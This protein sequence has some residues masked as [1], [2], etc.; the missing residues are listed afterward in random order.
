MALWTNQESDVI[1]SRISWNVNLLFYFG[2]ILKSIQNSRIEILHQ[3]LIRNS[4]KIFEEIFICS[5][6]VLLDMLFHFFF[7]CITPHI[8]MSSSLRWFSWKVNEFLIG[9]H[10]SK[11]IEKRIC[12]FDFLSCSEHFFFSKR[13][14]A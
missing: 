12:H 13:F 7:C 3:L 10:V 2:I 1:N 8:S 11:C 6:I 9:R 5:I 14:L 4:H